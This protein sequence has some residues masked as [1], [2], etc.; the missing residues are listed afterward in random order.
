MKLTKTA[1]AQIDKPEIRLKL[2]LGLA[3]SE[4]WV[5]SLISVNKDN[6]HLTTAKA[7][8]IIREET[9]LHDDQIL[10]ESDLKEVQDMNGF[11]S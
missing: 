2:A 10:E 6:G 4:T 5:R 3:F 1:L 11:G 8:Q 9:G 7:L